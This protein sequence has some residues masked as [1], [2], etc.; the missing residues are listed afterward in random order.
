MFTLLVM[1]L[2][3]SEKFCVPK[4]IKPH[5]YVISCDERVIVVCTQYFSTFIVSHSF[6]VN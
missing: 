4:R 3:E 5:S 6:L 2:G 1:S